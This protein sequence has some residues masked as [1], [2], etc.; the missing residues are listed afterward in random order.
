MAGEAIPRSR[1]RGVSQPDR[2]L[3]R[4]AGS[5]GCQLP[6]ERRPVPSAVPSQWGGRL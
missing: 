5:E 6:Q 2:P 4:A 3:R 1:R